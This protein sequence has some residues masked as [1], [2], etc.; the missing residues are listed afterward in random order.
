[1]SPQ[2][3]LL[4][5]G[6]QNFDQ[7]RDDQ[8]LYVDKTRFIPE[9]RKHGKFIFCARPHGFGKSVTCSTLKSFYSGEK[10]LFRGLAAEEAINSP[11]FVARPIIYLDMNLAAGSQTQEKLNSKLIAILNSNAKRHNVALKGNFPAGAFLS[12][13]ADVYN[14]HSQTRIALIIDD[15]DAPIV[16]LAHRDKIIFNQKLFQTTGTILE[17]FYAQIKPAS[18]FLNFA[19]ITGVTESSGTEILSGLNSLSDITH[20][21]ELST[22]MGFTREEIENNFTKF[23]DYADYKFQYG[24][25]E[26]LERLKGY[27]Y[28]YSFDCLSGL[29]NPQDIL[30]F[31]H[32]KE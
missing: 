31:F 19:F 27:Y 17:R 11:N 13:L 9:L 26:L 28:G 15:Y 20:N 18:Q 4:P 8:T 14:K 3:S 29:Y 7:I 1:L 24:I 22:I 32:D 30:N 16:K 10:E 23:I 5:L 12:L 25:N 2:L 6:R 21:T